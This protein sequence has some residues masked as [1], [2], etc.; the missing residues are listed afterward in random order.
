MQR[1]VPSAYSR[2]NPEPAKWATTTGQVA[3][4]TGAFLTNVASIIKPTPEEPI[5]IAEEEEDTSSPVPW[6]I[7]GLVLLG[8]VAGGVWL[9][10]GSS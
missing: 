7:G 2:P 1:F 5:I 6:I 3:G 10:R 4:A 8:A 9:M